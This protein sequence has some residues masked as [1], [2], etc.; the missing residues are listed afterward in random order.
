MLEKLEVS[1]DRKGFCAAVLT[2]LS[3][4]LDCI[5]HDLLIFNLNAYGLERNALKL[6]YDY[7]SNRLQKTNVE[8]SLLK[9]NVQYLFRY[10]LRCFSGFYTWANVI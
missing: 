10:C 1:R 7:F 6:V 5:C 9:T 8:R 2:D 3:K 4:A